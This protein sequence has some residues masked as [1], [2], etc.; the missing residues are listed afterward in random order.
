MYGEG[1][2]KISGSPGDRQQVEEG[3]Q[4]QRHQQVGRRAA[5]HKVQKTALQAIFA[6]GSKDGKPQRQ[7]LLAT[8]LLSPIVG[9][10]RKW[11][12]LN[13]DSLKSCDSPGQQMT[14]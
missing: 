13:S 4:Q 10:K 2:K 7:N 14:R 1:G 5:Q 3:F 11:T 6:F 12:D 9:G 8:K